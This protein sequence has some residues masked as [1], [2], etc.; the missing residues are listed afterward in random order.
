MNSGRLSLGTDV[1]HLKKFLS[2][3]TGKQQKAIRMIPDH[4]LLLLKMF[5][6]IQIVMVESMIRK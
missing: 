4:Y 2:S 6:L 1:E 5:Q 3:Y